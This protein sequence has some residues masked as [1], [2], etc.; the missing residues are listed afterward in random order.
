MNDLKSA[1]LRHIAVLLSVVGAVFFAL[2]LTRQEYYSNAA[3]RV[4]DPM[5]IVFE[6]VTGVL[7]LFLVLDGWWGLRSG[8]GGRWSGLWSPLL[9]AAM[10]VALLVMHAAVLLAGGYRV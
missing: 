6:V 1:A 5:H 3:D 8:A 4:F 2:W 9:R 10:G 7:A